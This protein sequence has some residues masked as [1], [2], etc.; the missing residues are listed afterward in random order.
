MSDPKPT[1]AE[2]RFGILAAREARR[3]THAALE[4]AKLAAKH[5]DALGQQPAAAA[6][7]IKRDADS[8]CRT[9][10][11]VDDSVNGIER[12]DDQPCEKRLAYN[13]SQPTGDS[14]NE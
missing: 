13:R 1:A 11:N 3:Y 2:V 12:C 4:I 9:C 10:G 5:R 14:A 8:P 7:A 6:A